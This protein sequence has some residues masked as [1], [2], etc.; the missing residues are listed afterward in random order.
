MGLTC[1][2]EATR[3]NHLFWHEDIT[4]SYIDSEA[5][6]VY[7]NQISMKGKPRDK[8]CDEDDVVNQTKLESSK[9]S[10][11]IA[12][13]QMLE[14][15]P[16]PRFNATVQ[17]EHLHQSSDKKKY[18]LRGR[19]AERQRNPLYSEFVEA[20]HGAESKITAL[21]DSTAKLQD[22]TVKGLELKI[23]NLESMLEKGNDIHAQ[24]KRQGEIVKQANRDVKATKKDLHNTSYRLKGMKSPKGKLKNII[25]HSN[26]GTPHGVAVHESFNKSAIVQRSLPSPVSLP[27]CNSKISKQ[28]WISKGVDQLCHVL[29]Q[30]EHRQHEIGK[31]QESRRSISNA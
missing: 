1:C 4:E 23:H 27:S 21:W 11:D 8:T 29:G 17:S 12:I 31:D 10:N 19:M 30:V 20:E 22:I 26:H 6:T 16:L 9:L 14:T 13:R 15:I 28:K 5:A 25:C 2:S 24:V 18:S 7:V 3:N